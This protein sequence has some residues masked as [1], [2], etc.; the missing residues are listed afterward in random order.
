MYLVKCRFLLVHPPG[1][2]AN[3]TFHETHY[4]IVEI[5]SRLTETSVS[6]GTS[7]YLPISPQK[8]YTSTLNE[9]FLQSTSPEIGVPSIQS[10]ASLVRAWRRFVK[11]NDWWSDNELTSDWKPPFLAP[12]ETLD[13]SRANWCV[14]SCRQSQFLH[15]ALHRIAS[16]LSSLLQPA[17]ER[18]GWARGWQ[19]C[20]RQADLG[21]KRTVLYDR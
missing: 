1:C 18:N 5:Q 13:E 7:N 2:F 10:E 12:G 20:Y 17:Q 9:T 21:M 3:C 16:L 15:H 4:S 6:C 11:E 19:R 8:L 14:G